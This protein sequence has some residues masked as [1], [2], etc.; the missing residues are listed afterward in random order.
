MIKIKIFLEKDNKKLLDYEKEC[1][2]LNC[3]KGD[4][5]NTGVLPSWNQGFYCDY[6][7]K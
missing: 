1:I 3:E 6:E 4:Y 5:Y 7:W 2:W